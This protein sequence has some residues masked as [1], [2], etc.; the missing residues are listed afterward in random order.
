MK[1]SQKKSVYNI[2]SFS[3]YDNGDPD[4]YEKLKLSFKN[5]NPILDELKPFCEDIVKAKFKKWNFQ[6]QEGD[7]DCIGHLELYSYC[8]LER[9]LEES[10]LI[11]LISR[12]KAIYKFLYDVVGFFRLLVFGRFLNLSSKF[13]TVNQN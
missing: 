11:S 8:L 5:D 4:F 6:I 9:I 13:T 1:I 3:K 7:L 10:G 12:Q 2:G